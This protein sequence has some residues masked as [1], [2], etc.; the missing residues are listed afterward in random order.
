MLQLPLPLPLLVFH[1]PDLAP[2]LVTGNSPY[3]EVPHLLQ[4]VLRAPDLTTLL[5]VSDPQLLEVLQLFSCLVGPPGLR[6]TLECQCQL[7][8]GGWVLGLLGM[9]LPALGLILLEVLRNA[10]VR[11]LTMLPLCLHPLVLQAPGP[12][13]LLVMAD[14][15]ILKV[16]QLLLQG[17][18]P[19]TLLVMDAGPFLKVPQL[20][21]GEGKTVG[22]LL[23]H[24]AVEQL[25][26]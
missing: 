8:G 19:A 10:V 17:P 3:L 15:Q 2:P 24:G 11:V 9:E 6:R 21:P 16:L 25:C 12:T 4:L 14:S 5:V 1:A 20:L 7:C 13:S 18:G 22:V 26:H 23:R